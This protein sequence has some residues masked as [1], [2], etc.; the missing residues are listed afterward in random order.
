MDIQ[1]NNSSIGE[2][3]PIMPKL[4]PTLPIRRKRGL[5]YIGI[6]LGLIT[7]IVIT[8]AVTM[9]LNNNK[10]TS[11][12]TDNQNIVSYT[13]DNNTT[14]PIDNNPL[15]EELSFD[16]D[17]SAWGSNKT[18]NI[19]LT[20]PEGTSLKKEVKSHELG[21]TLTNGNNFMYIFLPYESFPAPYSSIEEV[22][23]NPQF[24]P[25]TRFTIAAE[26]HKDTF[27]YTSN[28]NLNGICTKEMYGYD[29]PCGERFIGTANGENI[30]VSCPVSSK[31]FCDD[32][33]VSLK[34]KT[35]TLPES[36]K[37]LSLEIDFSDWMNY[38]IKKFEL[39]NVSSTATATLVNE[40]GNRVKGYRIENSEFSLFLY[41]PYES[42]PG[43]VLLEEGNISN[44]QFGTIKRV[45]F[46]DSSDKSY[47]VNERNFFNCSDINMEGEEGKC[48][49]FYMKE[50]STPDSEYAFAICER[51]TQICDSIISTLKV[52]TVKK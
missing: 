50:N 29:E 30:F 52:S 24:G 3:T 32:L 43:R 13:V 48:A 46:N 36:T 14:L 21:Y 18:V 1:Q 16:I 44:E 8:I 20:V 38:T 40:Q 33:V 26:V 23:V 45:K 28:H 42:F 6:I 15:N 5:I 34:V 39:A 22:G 10:S 51:G 31:E 47:Y 19:K 12:S 41:Y 17:T 35:T 4:E 49:G 37:N 9:L 7:L 25:I 2:S 27:F 11:N